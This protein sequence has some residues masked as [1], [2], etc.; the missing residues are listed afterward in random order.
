MRFQAK[1]R[2]ASQTSTYARRLRIRSFTTNP[3]REVRP[4]SARRPGAAPASGGWRVG[5]EIA[6]PPPPPRT[7]RLSP[8]AWTKEI[9]GYAAARRRATSRMRR[10]RS[11]A[12]T[13]RAGPAPPPQPTGDPP[14]PPPPVEPGPGPAPPLP[15]EPDQVRARHP[16]AAEVA[17]QPRDVAEVRLQLRQ[18]GRTV[19]KLDPVLDSG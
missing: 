13:R 1:S 5:D 10:S 15:Q 19:E 2:V 3:S 8:S 14:P 9:S 16:R 18:G 11:T 17:V 6:A 12:I 7:G 4:I